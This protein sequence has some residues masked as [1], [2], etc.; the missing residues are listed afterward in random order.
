MSATTVDRNTPKHLTDDLVLP[1]AAATKILAG[2]MVARNASGYAVPA[3]DATGLR[4]LGRAESQADNTDGSAGDIE[5][6]IR[7]GIYLWENDETNP[8][9]D[10]HVGERCYVKDNQTV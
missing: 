8:V 3:S 9:T 4:V 1:V 10:A 5:A 2:I 6:T 7:P